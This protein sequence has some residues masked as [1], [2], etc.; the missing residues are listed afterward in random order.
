M[1]INF[2]QPGKFMATFFKNGKIVIFNLEN[3]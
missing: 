3:D 2:S 1:D